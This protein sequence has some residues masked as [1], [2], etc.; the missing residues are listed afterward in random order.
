MLIDDIKKRMFKAM[1]AGETV[2][3]EIL[4]TAIGEVTSTGETATDERV[5]KTLTKLVKSNRETL[6]VSPDEAQKEILLREIGILE[7]FLPVALTPDEISAALA[8]VADQ[9]RAAKGDG[10]A[11]GVAMK[12]LKSVEAVVSGQDVRAAV[13]AL[14]SS[15]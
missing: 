15:S 14:R 4:R 5:T 6:T 11:V 12:H 1:K 2:E 7:T 3:K 10:P 9:I 8:P 13:S